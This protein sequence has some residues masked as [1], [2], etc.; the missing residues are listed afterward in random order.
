MAFIAYIRSPLQMQ[1]AIILMP[2]FTFQVFQEVLLRDFL[3]VKGT[4]VP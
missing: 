2:E 1:M 4:L 3:I